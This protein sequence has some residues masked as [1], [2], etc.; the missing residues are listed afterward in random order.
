M[1][2]ARILIIFPLVFLIFLNKVSNGQ[3]D[4]YFPLDTERA[5][6]ENCRRSD[7]VAGTCRRVENCQRSVRHLRDEDFCSFSGR[8]AIYCCPNSAPRLGTSEIPITSV[9]ERECIVLVFARIVV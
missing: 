6:G 8:T 2:S 3:D 5:E 1:K 9:D 7:G 4:I